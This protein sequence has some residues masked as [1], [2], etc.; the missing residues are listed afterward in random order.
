MCNIVLTS[1]PLYGA[2]SIEGKSCLACRCLWLTSRLTF[3]SCNI[4]LVC[5]S[6]ILPWY[7]SLFLSLRPCRLSLFWS[8]NSPSNSLC[9][10]ASWTLISTLVV[11]ISLLLSFQARLCLLLSVLARLC[12]YCQFWPGCVYYCQFWF[13]C[14]YYCR[15]GSSLVVFTAD[16]QFG[17]DTAFS[18]LG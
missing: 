6:R 9:S 10:L 12:L 3:Y 2:L 13:G 1:S 11:L 17:H 7:A 18:L 14:A 8:I 5:L 16:I 4:T 15:S